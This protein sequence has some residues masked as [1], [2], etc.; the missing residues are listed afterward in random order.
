MKARLDD[1]GLY[2]VDTCE[3]EEVINMTEEELE[4]WH[5]RLGHASK[6]TIRR[7]NND[8]RM[9]IGQEEK[10]Q[11]HAKVCKACAEAKIT[12]TPHPSA[13]RVTNGLLDL[14]HSD[15]V[16]PLPMSPGASRYF[17]TFIDDCSRYKWVYPMKSKSQVL[18]KLQQFDIMIE[19]QFGIGI[20]RLRCD[21]GGEYTSKKMKRFLDENGILQ[22]L[23]M[24]YSP[25]QNG[26]A[27]RANRSLLET[28]T[29]MLYHA[30]MP[31]K[32]WAEAIDTATYILNRM[33]TTVLGGMS[34]YEIIH[35]HAP[36]IDHIRTFGCMAYTYVQR[37][38]K[39]EKR[40]KEMIMLG[41]SDQRKGYRLYDPNTR[42][43]VWSLDVRFDED[44]YPY[45]R[46]TKGNQGAG[47][48]KNQ[49]RQG[50]LISLAPERYQSRRANGQ[51]AVRDIQDFEE[52]EDPDQM[53]VE[54]EEEESKRED[55]MSED[56]LPDENMPMEIE[57]HQVIRPPRRDLTQQSIPQRPRPS[58]SLRIRKDSIPNMIKSNDNRLRLE[59]DRER[60]V[61][62]RDAKRQEAL[63]KEAAE[64]RRK[65]IERQ[66]SMEIE[67]GQERPRI[68][69]RRPVIE[70]IKENQL[71][72]RQERHVSIPSEQR[73]RRLIQSSQ[74]QQLGPEEERNRASGAVVTRAETQR[75]RRKRRKEQRRR[76]ARAERRRERAE[77]QRAY[78]E[79]KQQQLLIQDAAQLERAVTVVP[80]N[81][82]LVV[83]DERNLQLMSPE[84]LLRRYK[85]N[86]R[87]RRVRPQ[88]M[89]ESKE[90]I[91]DNEP[92]DG[93][94]GAAYANVTGVG[95]PKSSVPIPK[96]YKQ[97]IEGPNRE[98]WMKAMDDEM[99]S[100]LANETWE[101]RKLPRGRKPIGSKW[102]YDLK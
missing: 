75:E 92:Q 31:N 81:R 101:L 90:A 1:S 62:I 16:G 36:N 50:L 72:P 76:E 54:E 37:R 99:S 96:T 40:S 82:E 102:V 28:A 22:E 45:E 80:N 42:R 34:P 83:H 29:S 12:R 41:Y 52:K 65:W 74:D 24:P 6:K 23:T 15:V 87:K 67:D 9:L 49:R 73:E 51:E 57:E 88:G 78:L 56:D 17:V 20:R 98:Q 44:D 10:E 53:S 66:D 30:G 69:G 93:A 14:I 5:T 33:P 18:E 64:R 95:Q 97:A 91:E 13:P 60:R 94:H 55:Y 63:R 86:E 100:L 35:E 19:K 8:N 84:E 71:V 21:N 85:K 61:R 26:I 39:M 70:E 79:A 38:K 46:L 77:K 3:E 48:W 32:F 47:A 89:I 25:Q 4:R 43:V 58:T 27:E 2:V 11:S 68:M 7:G 59:T